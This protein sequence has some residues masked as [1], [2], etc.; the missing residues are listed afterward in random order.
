[1][2]PG[3]LDH[4]GAATS[5]FVQ[6]LQHVAH[7]GVFGP[8]Q[9]GYRLVKVSIR[10]FCGAA[11]ALDR[12]PQPLHSEFYVL[13]LQ[14]APALDF[15]LVPLFWKAL[16][17]FRGQLFGGRALSG[18][19][20]ADERVSCHRALGGTTVLVCLIGEDDASIVIVL[21]C[22]CRDRFRRCWLLLSD[23]C[24]AY[25][26]RACSFYPDCGAAGSA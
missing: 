26:C 2:V 17:I 8:W 15:G 6:M 13:R 11:A 5:R 12:L 16:E 22:P 25:G 9:T 7:L 19:F 14:M 10:S 3:R 20:L 23:Y 18:E 21:G 24:E 4:K 1:M